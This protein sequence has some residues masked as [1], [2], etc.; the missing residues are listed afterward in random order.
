MTSDEYNSVQLG[1]ITRVRS[2]GFGMRFV[3]CVF[4]VT[5][6]GFGLLYGE[7][8]PSGMSYTDLDRIGSSII[9]EN[10]ER[11]PLMTRVNN[12][13]KKLLDSDTQTLIKAG[14][15]NNDLQM[16]DAGRLAL[17]ATLFEANKAALVVLAQEELE[18]QEQ[19]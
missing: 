10:K 6:K 17:I 3:G 4:K 7:G 13:M 15:L 5:G 11:P 12:M 18:E 14:Y 19:N 16:T 2:T 1:E 9:K 8:I